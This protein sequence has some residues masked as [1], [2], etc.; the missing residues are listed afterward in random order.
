M[1]RFKI[2]ETRTVVTT[3]IVEAGDAKKALNRLRNNPE[4]WTL[5]TEVT[6]LGPAAVSIREWDSEVLEQTDLEFFQSHGIRR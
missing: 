5:D 4:R 3:H 6:N 1:P 2:T